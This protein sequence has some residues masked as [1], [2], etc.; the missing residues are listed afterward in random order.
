MN[1]RTEMILTEST[2][3]TRFSTLQLEGGVIW[4]RIAAVDDGFIADVPDDADIPYHG[5]GSTPNEAAQNLRTALMSVKNVLENAIELST[6]MRSQKERL[7]GLFACPA[8]ANVIGQDC[9]YSG[10][11]ESYGYSPTPIAHFELAA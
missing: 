6:P 1:K 9:A 3:Y 2:I 4:V 10:Y 5:E 7:D 8:T 11:R